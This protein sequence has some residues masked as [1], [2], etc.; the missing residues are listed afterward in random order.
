MIL[1]MLDL[2]YIAGYIYQASKLI[3]VTSAILISPQTLSCIVLLTFV[4]ITRRAPFGSYSILF[5]KGI[6]G[7]TA[8]IVLPFS[9]AVTYVVILSQVQIT[10]KGSLEIPYVAAITATVSAAIMIIVV[11]LLAHK[12]D[13]LEGRLR[14]MSVTDELT[15]AYN[16]RGLNLHGKQKLL[17][18]KRSRNPLTVL[19]IDVDGMKDVNDSLGHSVG[20]ELLRDVV[21]LLHNSFR[22]NDIVSRIGGDEFAVI[23]DSLDNEIVS[24]VHRLNKAVADINAS[25]NRPYTIGIS[26]GTV[27]FDPRTN[28]SLEH[29]IDR[30][31][32]AMYKIKKERRTV[33]ADSGNAQQ[34]G[35]SDA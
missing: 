22:E 29:L 8:R 28:E 30:A 10:S 24:A 18:A 4:Q 35:P 1:V 5:C 21:T 19:Y 25:G 32:A 12:I 34:V 6:A 3:K 33:A 7:H 11:T 14:N 2:L 26:I 13:G 23:A 9:V 31:D 15:G 20:S 16:L 27:S 17:D